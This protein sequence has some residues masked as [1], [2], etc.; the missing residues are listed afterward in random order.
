MNN[1]NEKVDIS[2]SSEEFKKKHGRP[3]TIS[4][5]TLGCPKVN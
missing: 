2:L 1:D 5:F 3:K 4:F